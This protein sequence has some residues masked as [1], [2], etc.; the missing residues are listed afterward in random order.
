MNTIIKG[1]KMQFPLYIYIY[2][3]NIFI[4]LFFFRKKDRNTPVM[5]R[6]I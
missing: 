3:F 6:H 2:I 4:Y 5:A 1:G